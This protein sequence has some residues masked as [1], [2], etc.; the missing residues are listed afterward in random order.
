[1]N[2]EKFC[3]DQGLQPSSDAANYGFLK[4]ELLTTEKATVPTMK[5][6]TTLGGAVR[7]FEAKFE[8]A[9]P[10]L[11]YFDSR[12]R[13][14]QIALDV[15]KTSLPA[16]VL[17]SIDPDLMYQ[18]VATTRSGN[19]TFWVIDQFNNE[20]E[21]ILIQKTDGGQPQILAHGTT[22]F[23]LQPGIVPAPAAVALSKGAQGPGPALAPVVV[24]EISSEEDLTKRVFAKAEDC[25]E[26]LVTRNV[27]GTNGGHLACAWAVNRVVTLA[28]GKPV[29]GG[30]STSDMFN[31]LRARH[32][33]VFEDGIAAGAIVISPTVGNN[34]GHVGVVGQIA[35]PISNTTIYSNSSS[36]GIFTHVYTLG[37][38]K[39]Y[40]KSRKD[41]Q[42]R[43]Y[44]LNKDNL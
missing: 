14:G 12:D 1:M 5:Q 4:R 20:G 38:W 7:A 16:D 35:N 13:W 21:Q 26:T 9:N 25:D 15:F 30:L 39:N 44:V 40:F 2:F 18:V 32:N 29:G 37:K 24:P 36:R 28:L 22:V 10:E 27:P 41:L 19:T 6:T 17:R 31:V 34:V 8:R 42:V 33:E 23:P 43:F 11:I 3:E